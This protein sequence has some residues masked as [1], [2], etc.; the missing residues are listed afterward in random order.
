MVKIEKHNMRWLD[1]FKYIGYHSVLT[2]GQA[3]LL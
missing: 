2:E 1:I 3:E